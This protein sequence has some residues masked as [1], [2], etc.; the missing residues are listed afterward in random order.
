MITP[1]SQTDPEIFFPEHRDAARAAIKVCAGCPL[2]ASCYEGAIKRG[3]QYG[4]WGGVWVEHR[5]DTGH[6]DN[7]RVIPCH[8]G[9]LFA[10]YANAKGARVCRTCERD[11]AAAYER[12]HRAKRIAA[13]RARR[14]IG[15][16][17]LAEVAAATK[18][19][20]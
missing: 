20:S 6:P 1:C 11:N 16:S 9:H 17:R 13:R 8:R 2:K 10:W 3:E 4:I 15:N 7:A 14:Q 19:R 12:R 5:K 18:G